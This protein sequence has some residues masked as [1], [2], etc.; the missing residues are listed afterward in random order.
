MIIRLLVPIHPSKAGDMGEASLFF[1]IVYRTFILRFVIFFGCAS[2]F[3]DLFRGEIADRSLHYYFMTPVRREV[4]AA[5]K[6]LAGILGTIAVFSSVTLV[7]YIL[8]MVRHGMGSARDFFLNGPG[9]THLTA[10]IGATCMACIGY[11]AMC[12]I[13]GLWF[14]NPII[15]VATIFGWEWLY[16]LLP[17]L[18][19]KIS[20]IHYLQ[21]I[22]PVP[23]D[24]GPWALIGE[25]TP[26][27]IAVPGFLVFS[28]L[29][30][31]GSALYIQR[32]EIRYESD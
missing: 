1:A 32:M 5:G 2:I 16:F 9:L 31:S 15:P 30:L 23:L 24:A 20:V 6:Y 10:Y 26:V 18:L 8:L 21:S 19:K 27:W 29:V 7:S 22:F 14:R 17:S 28:A 11:G 13:L 3:T 4:L 25:P 12:L